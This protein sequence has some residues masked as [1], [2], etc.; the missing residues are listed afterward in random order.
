MPS[1]PPGVSGGHVNRADAREPKGTIDLFRRPPFDS[2][3][4]WSKFRH[5]VEQRAQDPQVSVYVRAAGRSFRAGGKEVSQFAQ[6]QPSEARAAR[7]AA[8]A[9]RVANGNEESI[10]VREPSSFG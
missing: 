9:R 3:P 2:G 1:R 5:R 8:A 7:V 10:H 4:W 6:Q